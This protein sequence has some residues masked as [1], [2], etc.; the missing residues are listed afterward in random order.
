MAKLLPAGPLG[1]VIAPLRAF[2]FLAARPGLWWLV[3]APFIINMGLFALFF[4]FSYTRFGQWIRAMIPE[5]QGWAWQALLYLLVFLLIVFLLALEVYLFLLVGRIIAAPF[6]EILTL[7]VERALGV[8]QSELIPMGVWQGILRV[9]VQEMKKLL[10]YLVLMLFLLALNFLPGVGS[11]FAAGL[12]FLVT[13]FFLAVD[14]MDYPLERRGLSL[15]AKLA[16]VGRMGLTGIGFG[17]TVLTMGIVPLLNLALLPL[18]AVGGTLLFWDRA[19]EKPHP[20][21][22]AN[23]PA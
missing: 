8:E 7:K 20:S 5:G 4:W 19:Q 15:R 16:F 13:C 1:G 12:A 21:A 18:A 6:L 2:G 3:A 11:V 23:P 9:L 10:I 14:F 22:P 17:A